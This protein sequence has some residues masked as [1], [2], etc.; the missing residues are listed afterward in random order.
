MAPELFIKAYTA[1][2]EEYQLSEEAPKI[3]AKNPAGEE[4]FLV[5]ASH[6]IGNVNFEQMDVSFVEFDFLFYKR[7]RTYNVVPR[8][9]YSVRVANAFQL[10]NVI[11]FS[12]HKNQSKQREI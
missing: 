5:I 1:I 10:T 3:D 6:T 12:N 4:V 11:T 9:E 2:S 7:C 8:S